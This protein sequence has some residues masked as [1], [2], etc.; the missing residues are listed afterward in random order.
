MRIKFI[1]CTEKHHHDMSRIVTFLSDFFTHLQVKNSVIKLD[2]L[3]ISRCTQCRVCAQKS[4]CSPIKCFMNDE[5]NYAIDEIE[6]ADAYVILSDTNSLFSKNRV[7]SKFSQR[8]VAYYY[9]P[10]GQTHS[11][12]RNENMDKHSII[13]NYNTTKYFANH[14]FLTSK[15]MLKDTSVS[16][17]AKVIDYLSIKPKDEDLLLSYKKEL[18]AI[19][20][21]LLTSL[22]Q[23]SA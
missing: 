4:S 11:T 20:T 16:I 15:K 10:F 3:R 13:I 6:E 21:K 12:P 5:M 8:L 14:S 23:Y 17:G 7:H 19:A 22:Q 9:W 18:T 2:D 1:D